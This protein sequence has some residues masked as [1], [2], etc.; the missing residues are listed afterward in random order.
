MANRRIIEEVVIKRKKDKLNKEKQSE[1]VKN[2]L[3]SKKKRR[4]QNESFMTCQKIVKDHRERQKSH[5]A[6]RRKSVTNGK[7]VGNIYDAGRENSSVIV[8]RIAG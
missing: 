2:Q 8:I 7:H 5:S 1:K 4:D 6:F 3:L